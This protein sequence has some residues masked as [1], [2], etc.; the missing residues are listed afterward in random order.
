MRRELTYILFGGVDD[1]QL[2]KHLAPA[3][4]PLGASGYLATKLKPEAA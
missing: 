3:P 2:G 4:S 1:W